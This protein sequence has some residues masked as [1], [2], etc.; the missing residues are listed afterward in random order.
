[1]TDERTSMN[2]F[3]CRVYLIGGANRR[4]CR[5]DGRRMVKATSLGAI[6]AGLA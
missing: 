2:T 3:R 4:R 5:G 6:P 1:M